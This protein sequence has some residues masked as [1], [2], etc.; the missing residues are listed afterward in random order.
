MLS[1][2][3][4]GRDSSV[5]MIVAHH[6]ASRIRD[7]PEPVRIIATSSGTATFVP[8]HFGYSR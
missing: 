5:T 2:Q 1:S 7:V 4:T 6:G 8:R 3:T